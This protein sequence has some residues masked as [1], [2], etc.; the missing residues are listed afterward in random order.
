[1]S[2]QNIF[3]ELLWMAPEVHVLKRG[4]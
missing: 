1:M 2:G 4:Y 3:I